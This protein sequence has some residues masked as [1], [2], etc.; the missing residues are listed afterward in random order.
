MEKLLKKKMLLN[1]CI[2][3]QKT[4]IANAK[5]AL[6]SIQESVL[7][8]KSSIE[9]SM[10]S[11]RESLQS[12]REMYSRQVQESTEGLAVLSR[13]GLN[14]YNTVKLGAVVETNS[15]N[16]FISISLG[17]IKIENEKFIAI[18][19]NTPIYQLIA[20]KKKGDI[21]NFRGQDSTIL[22]VY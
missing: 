22:D 15:M 10:E 14:A 19:T 2:E 16:Y 13:I 3:H 4:S 9:D 21:F 7:E 12:D 18:S 11:F 1:N 17:E 6:A 5:K 8:E 20:G